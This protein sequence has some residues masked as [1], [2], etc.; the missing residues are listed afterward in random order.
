MLLIAHRG[1]SAGAPE[2][3]RAAFDRALAAGVDGIE[4][5]VR[6]CADRVLV[7]HDADLSRYGGSR[8]PLVRR[9]WAGLADADVGAWFAPRFRG[10]RPLDLD[11]LLDGWGGQLELLIELKPPRDPRGRHRLARLVADAVAARSLARWTWILG[12]D[13]A[14]LR[15]VR[16]RRPELRLMWN[17][18][19]PPADLA[20][21][22]RAGVQAIDCH[23]GILTPAHAQRIRAAGLQCFAYTAN[24][25]AA[26]RHARACGLDGVMSDRA[27]WLA[28]RRA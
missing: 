20:P 8:T 16:R 12:F 27:G 21:A 18:G 24:T 6:L 1:D 9:R 4:T 17:R 10:Q 15:A 23:L 7:C 2:N 14:S 26:L 5:D 28:A 19:A 25:A 22:L 3:T 11:G 13:L